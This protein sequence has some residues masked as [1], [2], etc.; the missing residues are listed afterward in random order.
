[1]QFIVTD[2]FSPDQFHIPATFKRGVEI[3]HWNG[4]PMQRAVDINANKVGGSNPA[5]RFKRGLESMTFRSM[6]SILPPDEHWVSI[7][8]RTEEGQDLEYRQDWLVFSPNREAVARDAASGRSDY[9]TKMG[10]DHTIDRIRN[11]KQ[12]IF[13]TPPGY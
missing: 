12:I 5:A 4:I 8:Y 7:S 13:G 11:M 6:D 3:T 9:S 2:V 1:M 10:I